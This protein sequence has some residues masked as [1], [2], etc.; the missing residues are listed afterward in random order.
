M[1]KEVILMSNIKGLGAEGDVVRVAEGY[2]RNY[3][4]PRN[5]AAPVNAGTRRQLEKNRVV[6][7]ANQAAK[8]AD[9]EKLVKQIEESSCSIPVKTGPE[10]KL[11][12]SV[13]VLDIVAALAEQGVKLDKTQVSLE[14]SIK[15][16]GVYK[17]PVNLQRGIQA[18][19]KV[20]VVEE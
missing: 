12:G 16:L 4:L 3:L 15:E 2:A 13:T 9:S 14:E 7:A 1:A 8:T 19:L 5:L 20:W 18:T 17:V 11:F 10:G 6:Q